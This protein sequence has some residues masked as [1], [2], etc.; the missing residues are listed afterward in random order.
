M[1]RWRIKDGP[2][3]L[4]SVNRLGHR[5]VDVQDRLLSTGEPVWIVVPE[6]SESI[7]DVVDVGG[8]N[9]VDVKI[10]GVQLG[11]QPEPPL[12]IPSKRSS[13]ITTIPGEFLHVVRC[14]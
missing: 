9:A 10:R 1:T 8:R 11:T 2:V 3:R 13:V 5:I 12:L 7:H 4:A 14:V 6:G